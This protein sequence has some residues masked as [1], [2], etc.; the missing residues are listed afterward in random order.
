MRCHVSCRFMSLGVTG[1]IHKKSNELIAIIKGSSTF[2][3]LSTLARP[4]T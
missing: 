4:V 2:I 3:A 1:I